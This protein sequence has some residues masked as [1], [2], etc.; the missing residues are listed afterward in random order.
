MVNERDFILISRIEHYCYLIEKAIEKYH[1]TLEELANDEHQ[2]AACCMHIFQI[3]ESVK[4][5]S[6]EFTKAHPQ[7]PWHYMAG[8]RDI[9]GH[10]YQKTDVERVWQTMI[11]DIPS[12][13]KFCE[14]VLE[15]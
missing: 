11:Y 14:Q 2:L 9:F 1:L 13:K 3:G 8:M 6:E 10:D 15:K 4:K 12:L 7:Q 5:L